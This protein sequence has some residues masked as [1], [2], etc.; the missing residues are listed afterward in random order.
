MVAAN[1][2]AGSATSVGIAI[3]CPPSASTSRTVA[4]SPS[5]PRARSAMRAP[6]VANLRAVALPTPADAPVITTI[7]GR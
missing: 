3:A 4:A 7:S 6:A 1:T 2:C 5:C